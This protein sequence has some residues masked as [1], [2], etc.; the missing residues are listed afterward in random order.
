MLLIIT[1]RTTKKSDGQG[2][3][4]NERYTKIRRYDNLSISIVI[5]YFLAADFPNLFAGKPN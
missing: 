3:P 5:D 2:D 4:P 1:Y